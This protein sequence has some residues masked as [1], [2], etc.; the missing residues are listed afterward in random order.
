MKGSGLVLGGMIG[1]CVGLVLSA[2]WYI[3]GIVTG[4]GIGRKLYSS[5]EKDCNE[6][7]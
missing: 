5:T 2:V 1:G 6:R 7:I 3:G 4:I